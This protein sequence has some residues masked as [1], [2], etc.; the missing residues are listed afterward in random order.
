MMT[1]Q[2]ELDF[3]K[4][5]IW[6]GGRA[7]RAWRFFVVDAA[8]W[9]PRTGAEARALCTPTPREPRW[10]GIVLLLRLIAR[11]LLWRPTGRR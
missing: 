10:G 9:F 4:I 1:P 5:N 11:L 2:Q 8:N 7:A 6:F 3:E